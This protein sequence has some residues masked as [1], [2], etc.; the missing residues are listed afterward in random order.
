MKKNMGS[1]DR[2]VRMIAGIA[3]ILAAI[4]LTSGAL[5]IVLYIFGSLWIVTSIVG[6]CP[7]YVPFNI[8]TKKQ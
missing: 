8:S 2:T 7:L 4:F 5:D 1:T 3:F 6:T